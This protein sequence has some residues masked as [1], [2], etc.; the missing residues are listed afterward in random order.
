LLQKIG[1]A[2][3]PVLLIDAHMVNGVRG[4]FARLCIQ[5]NLDKPLPK[6]ILIRQNRVQSVQYEGINQLCFCCGRIGHQKEFCPFVVKAPSPEPS[7]G[8]DQPVSSIGSPNTTVEEPFGEWMVVT[9]KKKPT[10]VKKAEVTGNS[11]LGREV[12]G[13]MDLNND[14]LS[15]MAPIVHRERK[16]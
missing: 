2:I 1:R 3:G 7:V 16:R 5:V 6:T 11:G 10:S 4:R 12:R 9:R 13:K 14:H 15:D 8:D